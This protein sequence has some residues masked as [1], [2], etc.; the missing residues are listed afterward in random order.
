L[1]GWHLRFVNALAGE[2]DL[3]AREELNRDDIELVTLAY[4]YTEDPPVKSAGGGFAPL[5]RMRGNVRVWLALIN[6]NIYYPY[7]HSK[8]FAEYREHIDKWKTTADKFELWTYETSFADYMVYI[9]VMQTWR[10]NLNLYK[11]LPADYVFMQSTNEASGLWQS[12]LNCYVAAKMLWNPNR[13]VN[14][15]K[16][17]FFRLYYGPGAEKS[18]R[19]LF[20]YERHFEANADFITASMSSLHKTDLESLQA[21]PTAFLERQVKLIDEALSDVAASGLPDAQKAA[22]SRRV[23]GLKVTPLFLLLNN[24]ERHYGGTEG[25]A[26]TAREFC[27]IMDERGLSLFNEIAS[28]KIGTYKAFREKMLEVN[29][30]LQMVYPF[31]DEAYDVII[32]A[33]QSNAEACG[34]GTAREPFAP[35]GRIWYLNGGGKEEVV[36]NDPY[37]MRIEVSFPDPVAIGLAGEEAPQ[38]KTPGCLSLSFAR[39]YVRAGRL[40]DGRK[41]LILECAAGGTGFALHHWV[42][43]GLMRDR[44]LEVIGIALGLNAG[45]RAAAF[46]WH[47]GEHD[48]VE[49]P[50]WEFS[51]KYAYHSG[52]LKGLAE[53]V[54]KTAANPNM[55]FVAGDFVPE[56]IAANAEK[57]APIQKAL[58]DAC[59]ALPCAAFAETDGLQSNNQITGDG[60]DI[61]FCRRSL[62]ELGER[63]FEGYKNIT[64]I[65]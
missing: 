1:S 60:D 46:L 5:V 51:D 24:Y 65:E 34:K 3:W 59:G 37:S 43:R 11:S 12:L 14:A 57:C 40:K 23:R 56:W 39:E 8:Q 52:N 9:P 28:Y 15:L 58:R 55:P 47:Q 35:D 53:A 22:Y 42:R 17:E 54:R 49:N 50:D 62:Y 64:K 32:V 21:F 7:R 2:I 48:C 61:H 19:M 20:E 36:K 13:D 41:L 44:L 4:G 16:E 31:R 27:A 25:R 18:L 6:T 63:Y 45:N 30:S 29:K 38:G 33:G 10:E 26:E